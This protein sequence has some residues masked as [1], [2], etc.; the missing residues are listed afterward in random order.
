MPALAWLNDWLVDRAD[1]A[2]LIPRWNGLRVVAGDASVF[3][4]AIRRC[5]R[6]KNLAEAD[7]RLFALYLPGAELVLHA[8]LHSARIAERAMLMEALECLQPNDVLVLDRGYPS[9][10]LLAA[11][12][13]RGIRFVIRCD[14]DSGWS[15]VKAFSRSSAI[16]AHVT[17][18]GP[19]AQDAEDWCCPRS[20]LPVR[21]VKSVSTTGA[22]RVMVTNLDAKDVPAELFGDLYHQRWRVEEAFKRLKHRLH[23]ESVSG[24]SQHAVLVDVAAKVLADNIASLLSAAAVSTRAEEDASK[25]DRP[26]KSN[27]A[28]AAHTIARALPAILLRVGSVIDLINDVIDKLASDSRRTKPGRSNPRP[29]RPYKPHPALSQKG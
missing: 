16:E 23:L 19:G 14:N 3:M 9:S 12:M 10:W 4:P 18:N 29:T 1:R 17:I 5:A 26:R 15:Q 6:T 8:S 7:Q 28:L 24:L 13:Q 25:P 20:P 2:G 21:L 27:R 22:Q 11:L